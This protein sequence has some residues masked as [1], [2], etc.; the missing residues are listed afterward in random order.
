MRRSF[1]FVILFMTAACSAELGTIQAP[2]ATD[3]PG[4]YQ[5]QV[6]LG[7]GFLGRQIQVFVDGQEILSITG[8]DEIEE[9]AQLLGTKIL[10]GGLTDAQ[11][12]TVRVVVN[13]GPPF[14]QI[15][16][17]GAGRYIHVYNQETGL[18][19]FNTEVLILE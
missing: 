15:I 17:L 9:H 4:K 13:G 3:A 19:V 12:V 11:E 1:L 6:G 18:Q 14:E 8:S 16:D 2:A 5:Y 10:A 7:Y